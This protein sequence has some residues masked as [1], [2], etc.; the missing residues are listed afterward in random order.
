[1]TRGTRD[2]VPS[3]G[4]PDMRFL[5]Q[6]TVFFDLFDAQVDLVVEAAASFSRLA[7]DFGRLTDEARTLDDI[8]H[9][10]DE[11]THELANRVDAMF[12][13]PFDKEDISSLYGTLDD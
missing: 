6:D 3:S 11:I 1:M 12:V 8:E 4:D 10:A 5:P 7:S 13:T 9:R 2:R